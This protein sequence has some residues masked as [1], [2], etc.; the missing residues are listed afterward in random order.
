ME[1]KK[2]AI[3]GTNSFLGNTL[4][5]S[6]ILSGFQ[7]LAFGKSD[8]GNATF[9]YEFNYPNKVID[10]SYLDDC[11][12][13]IYCAA[14]GVQ[15]NKEYSLSNIYWIN[16]FLPIEIVNYLSSIDYKGNMITFGTYFEIGNNSDNRSYSEEEVLYSSKAIPNHY[17]NSKRLLSRFYSNKNFSIHWYH[18]IL[19]SIYGKG[20]NSNR[21]IPY[22]ID[23][24]QN[25]KSMKLSSGQQIR[26]YVHV[27]DLVTTIQSCINNEIPGDVYNVADD[28]AISI[29]ELTKK[30]YNAC[31]IEYLESDETISKMDESMK[32]LI[33]NSSKLKKYLSN[34]TL[35]TTIDQGIKSYLD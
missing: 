11:D 32:I 14:A 29:K 23:S 7:V 16:T 25:N 34:W 9:F 24:L 10:Y 30:I 1:N 20:E 28:N 3:I 27:K 15:S 5:Q 22:L 4:S 31:G 21:L 19:P 26:Q 33:L 8:T 12:S 18:L 13:I 17:C 35:T 6:L 2:I